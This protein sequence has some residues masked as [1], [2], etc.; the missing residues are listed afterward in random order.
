M[1]IKLL[2][3]DVC[4]YSVL[5]FLYI[6]MWLED[7]A[8]RVLSVGSTMYTKVLFRQIQFILTLHNYY[9]HYTQRS[10]MFNVYL[11]SP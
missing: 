2:V 3:D 10:C 6:H 1:V 4:N 9:I 7:D 8:L 11:L 5:K